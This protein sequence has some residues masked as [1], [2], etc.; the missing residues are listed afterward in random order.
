MKF[1]LEEMQKVREINYRKWFNRFVLVHFLDLKIKLRNK[2]GFSDLVIFSDDYEKKN[3]RNIKEIEFVDLLRE[4]Y[5]NFIITDNKAF[6]SNEKY[7]TISWNTK[8]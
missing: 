3:K 5:P 8:E 7:I 1:D 6:F 2:Q 4:I